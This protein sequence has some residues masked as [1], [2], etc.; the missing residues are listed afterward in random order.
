M[1][2]AQVV[3]AKGTARCVTSFAWIPPSFAWIPPS[4]A[5]RQRGVALLCALPLLYHPVSSTAQ[6]VGVVAW[7]RDGG[8]DHH[9]HPHARDG[10]MLPCSHAPMLPCYRG[11]LVR[12]SRCSSQTIVTHHLPGLVLPRRPFRERNELDPRRD[13]PCIKNCTQSRCI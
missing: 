1:N 8:R 2:F 11:A 5:S 13:P 7:A 9:S 10:V 3:A 12:S 6:A 4:L